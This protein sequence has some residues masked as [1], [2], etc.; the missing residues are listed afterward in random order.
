MINGN[1]V[2]GSGLTGRKRRMKVFEVGLRG[3]SLES[4]RSCEFGS[5]S[6]FGGT[7]GN[8]YFLVR[9]PSGFWVMLRNL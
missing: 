7:L 2:L 3:M 1:L 5:F 9:E 4:E 6:G 8:G